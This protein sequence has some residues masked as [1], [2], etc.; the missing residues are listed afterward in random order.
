MDYVVKGSDKYYN[1]L[2]LSYIAYSI[3]YIMETN[4]EGFPMA[5]VLYTIIAFTAIVFVLKRVSFDF[6]NRSRSVWSIYILLC[7]WLAVM[8]LRSNISFFISP[9][10]Y[11]VMAY[12]GVVLLLVKPLPFVANMFDFGYKFNYIYLFIFF[13]PIALSDNGITQMFLET[14]P[15]FAIYI[16]IANKYNSNKNIFLAFIVLM[17]AL[18]VA[19]FE[20]RRNLMLTYGLYIMFGGIMF[21][22]NGKAKSSEVKLLT[23]LLALLML[24]AGVGLYKIESSGMFSTISS[25]AT[26]NTRDGVFIAYAVDMINAKDI[27]IGRGMSGEYYNPG[28]DKDIESD[29]FKDYRE[30]IECGYLEWILKGGIIYMLLYLLL[31]IVAIWRGFKSKNAL[32]KASALIVFVQLIDMVPFGLHAF[33]LKAF[34]IWLAVSVCLDD[35]IRRM[36]DE[37]ITAEL[38][39]KKT[40]LLPW[41]KN[42]K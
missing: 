19:T 36:S 33:N 5:T 38:F 25:R 9:R 32:C 27:L 20:A 24:I 26:E 35:N 2:W 29:E 1:I 28:I 10:L 39:T 30:H 37:E 15:V 42:S 7:I 31:F 17:L 16:F 23:A 6:S 22:M 3:L 40:K 14:F 41:Q 4:F 34:M 13:V 8:Y 11:D 21:F 18:L 12:F